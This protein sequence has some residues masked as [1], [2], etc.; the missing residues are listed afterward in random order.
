M[1]SNEYPEKKTVYIE[2]CFEK[3]VENFN[4]HIYNLNE[5]ANDKSS[6]GTHLMD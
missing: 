3:E 6:V 5:N 2:I 1:E 4:V